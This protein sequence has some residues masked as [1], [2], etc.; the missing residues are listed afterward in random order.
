MS[1]G[2][3]K[4]FD[5]ERLAAP[6]NGLAGVVDAAFMPRLRELLAPDAAVSVTVELRA[7]R[8]DA[9]R[10]V[11]SGSVSAHLELVCQR[12]MEPVAQQVKAPIM[13]AV[14][15]DEDAARSLPAE[16]DPLLLEHGEEADLP[17]IV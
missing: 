6:G 3:P 1:A 15:R 10:L 5:P 9:K 7:F 8:D 12:C 4:R 14:V 11:L 16:L 17:A 2:L 13:L